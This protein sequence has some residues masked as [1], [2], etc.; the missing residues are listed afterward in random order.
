MSS[1]STY[2]L[3]RNLD[4][5]NSEALWESAYTAYPNSAKVQLTMG[6][7]QYKV[8]QAVTTLNHTQMS[9]LQKARVWFERAL[10]T[11]PSYGDAHFWVGRTAWTE[12]SQNSQI[13]TL[14]GKHATCTGLPDT[15]CRIEFCAFPILAVSGVAIGTV[16]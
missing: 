5:K 9:H 7:Q 12:V 3:Q 16:C 15:I 6:I 11:C 1:W 2:H 8:S 13:N 4:W 14:I 10:Q